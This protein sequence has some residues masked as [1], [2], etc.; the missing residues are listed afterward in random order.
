M[1]VRRLFAAVLM[2]TSGV[3]ADGPEAEAPRA[4]FER[5]ERRVGRWQPT[6]EERRFD[7][8]GWADDIRD[9]VRLAGTHGRPVFLFTHDGHMN[10]GRC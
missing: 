6:A 1:P 2:L 4:Q 10:V 5:V 7:E 9:A 3:A 8:I